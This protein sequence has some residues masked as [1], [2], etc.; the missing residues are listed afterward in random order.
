MADG[1]GDICVTF[2][3]EIYNHNDLRRT[4]EDLG[5]RFDTRS[6]TEVLLKAY[7]EWGE[8]CLER[9]T[10]MFAF[11]IFD[12]HRRLLFLARDR[13]GEKPLFFVWKRG[14]AFSF[15]SELKALLADPALPREIDP[16]ALNH[17]LAFGYVPG[18]RCMVA[19]CR[20]LPAGH[21]MTLSLDS[22]DLKLWRYWNLPERAPRPLT[23]ARELEDEL[24]HILSEAVRRQLQADVP[25]AVLLS[26]GID[27]SLVAALAARHSAPIRTFT[28]SLPGQG[29]F[30][31]TEQARLVSR[32][33]GTDHIELPLE[34][35]D[36]PDL[37]ALAAQCDEPMADSSM[38]P[39]HIL[40]R[41]VRQF[42][43]VALG[44]DGGD[45]LFGGYVHYGWLPRMQY[46]HGRAPPLLRRL[47]ARGAER[48]LPVGARGRT[49]VVGL[50]GSP[51]DLLSHTNLFFDAAARAD[52]VAPE[53]WGSMCR[54]P[55]PEQLK[56]SLP[57]QDNSIA[58]RAMAVDFTTYLVDDILTK[59]DRAS[60]LASLEVRAPWL[61]HDLIEFAF[62]S[63]PDELRATPEEL[64]I[65]PRRLARRLLPKE[66]DV[67]RK[68]GF[69][70][71]V[72]RWLRG[73]M[74]ERAQEIL[75]DVDPSIFDQRAVNRL[76]RN[77]ARGFRNGNRIFALL[78]FE[79]WRRR[80]GMTLAA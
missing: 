73:A 23:D 68:Q 60:M 79:L 43:T 57:V 13:A 35:D 10:G 32:H 56:P 8:A 50:G 28:I 78:M 72:D 64:K 30:D 29:K 63:V 77:Q 6:D 27:S 49:Y 54:S 34:S 80:Y 65:L 4:L 26:G 41:S 53:L 39:T 51:A 31:E 22:F 75:A 14:H 3:G 5:H 45:E 58:S 70:I 15:A 16:S 47:I 24:E 74:G 44:G 11:A 48:C 25:V 67:D 42:A 33:F 2:N 9:L 17:Y 71:P 18:D 69:S 36:L 59:V 52:L 38:I 1:N 7:R 55:S 76:M 46:W 61:D 66:L 12:A 40:S 62:G 19:G 21:A 37:E 20:K